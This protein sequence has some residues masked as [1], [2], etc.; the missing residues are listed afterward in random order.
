MRRHKNDTA[1]YRELT[2]RERVR[3]FNGTLR[4]IVEYVRVQLERDVT[5]ERTRNAIIERRICTVRRAI[6]QIEAMRP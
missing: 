6:S 2:H 5:S 3:S 1:T 4:N